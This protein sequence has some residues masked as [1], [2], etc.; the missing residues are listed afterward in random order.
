MFKV[1]GGR[2][3]KAGDGKENQECGARCSPAESFTVETKR[4]ERIQCGHVE[5]SYD[6]SIKLEDKYFKADDLKKQMNDLRLK[7]GLS[8]YHTAKNHHN[9]RLKL[10][11]GIMICRMSAQL[12]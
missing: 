9:A 3:Q 7:D 10:E 8:L 1:E 2:I 11:D 6:S 4:I 12:R 5:L